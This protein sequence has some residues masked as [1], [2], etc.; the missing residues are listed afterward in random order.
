MLDL[1]FASNNEHKVAEIQAA[2]GA[3]VKIIT[4][5]QAGINVNIPEPHN[6]LEANASE[7]STTIFNITGKNCFSEDTGL[8]VRALNGEPGVRSA[9]YSDGDR[10]FNNNI[11]KL[12]NKMENIIDRTARF[13]TVISLRMN[14]DE[15]FF[16]GICEGSIGFAL[17]G[18]GGFG[19][20][21]IFTPAGS[22][23]TF[24]EMSLEEKG[25]FSHRRKATD[26]MVAFLQHMLIDNQQSV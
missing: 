5:K 21:P 14:K 19:Y 22:D 23:K 6:T 15:F 25:V 3:V 16:E 1:V 10:R 17:K 9:R 26:K 11:E 24:G 12:F 13:R 4:L 2:I 8:E 7:K 18:T 20:D